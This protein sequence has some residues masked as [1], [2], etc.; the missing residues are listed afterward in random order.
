MF[1]E[2]AEQSFLSQTHLMCVL[3]P[4]QI[5]RDVPHRRHIFR[6]MVLPDAT[7]VFIECDIQRPM[8]LIFDVPMLANHPDKRVRRPPQTGNIKTVITGDWGLLVRHPNG[9]VPSTC[10]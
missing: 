7:A 5:E 8:Q 2:T 6:G 10:G 3:L 9:R 1:V 4:Q